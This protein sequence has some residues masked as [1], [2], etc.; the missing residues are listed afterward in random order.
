[1]RNRCLRSWNGPSIRGAS[2]ASQ[3]PGR[4]PSRVGRRHGDFRRP[5]GQRA[6]RHGDSRPSTRDLGSERGCQPAERI[7]GGD[8]YLNNR[9]APE[10]G[11]PC[12]DKGVAAGLRSSSSATGRAS[13]ALDRWAGNGPEGAE[14]AAVARARPDQVRAGRAGIEELTRVERHVSLTH[15]AAPRTPHRGPQ[16]YIGRVPLAHGC[17]TSVSGPKTARA[18]QK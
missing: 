17:Q 1:V 16:Q 13:G 8:P 5:G 11:S 4:T 2:S 18:N 7:A 15:G 12:G 9:S 3:I 6:R 10:A 14:D